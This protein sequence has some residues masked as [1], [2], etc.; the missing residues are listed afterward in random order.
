M[1]PV[2]RRNP[3]GG[4]GTTEPPQAHNATGRPPPGAEGE[5]GLYDRIREMGRSMG[6]DAGPRAEGRYVTDL[7][8]ND[9][10]A[11]PDAIKV[12]AQDRVI[13]MVYVLV[14]HLVVLNVVEWLIATSAIKTF[15]AALLWMA[16]VYTLMFAVLVAAV[17]ETDGDLRIVFNYVNAQASPTRAYAHAGLLWLVVG[18]A[19]LTLG[20]TPAARAGPVVTDADRAALNRKLESVSSAIWYTLAVLSVAM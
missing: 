13:F 7:V 19:I 17:N 16:G 6:R 5:R 10:F 4:P 8:R 1:D 18:I 2:A 9:S 14:S 11:N 20:A 15:R 12:T 3:S